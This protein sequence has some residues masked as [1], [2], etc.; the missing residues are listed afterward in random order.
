MENLDLTIV[1]P[2]SKPFTNINPQI[3]EMCASNPVNVT[4]PERD[5]DDPKIPEYII[6]NPEGKSVKWH[7]K[8][9]KLG[10]IYIISWEW[11]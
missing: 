2:D 3:K 4:V 6:K 9:P 1:F 10:T 8:N 5:S 11:K 7:I